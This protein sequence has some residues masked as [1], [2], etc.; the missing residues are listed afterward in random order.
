MN[1]KNTLAV[2]V[3]VL[4]AA[5]VALGGCSSGEQSQKTSL[6]EQVVDSVTATVAENF[7]A[8]ARGEFT[9]SADTA[10]T[11]ESAHLVAQISDMVL[12]G[13]KLY[14]VFDG[15]VIAYDFAR[16]SNALLPIDD[17]LTTIPPN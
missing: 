17:T 4:C 10:A 12:A 3:V 5:L 1:W 2:G 11:S 13:P 16:K 15:G 7:A 14:A 8:A 6:V 9:A